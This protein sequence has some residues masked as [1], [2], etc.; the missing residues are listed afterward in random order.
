MRTLYAN[1]KD[2]PHLPFLKR[3]MFD[4]ALDCAGAIDKPP[5]SLLT[6]TC[7]RTYRVYL[8]PKTF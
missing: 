6:P 1:S 5:Y 3:F 7:K 2:Y 8:L 4:E